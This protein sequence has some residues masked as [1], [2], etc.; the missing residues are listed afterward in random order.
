MPRSNQALLFLIGLVLLLHTSTQLSSYKALRSN[1]CPDTPRPVNK[2]IRACWDY[3]KNLE[4]TLV[5]KTDVKT[6][7]CL[8]NISPDYDNHDLGVQI[9]RTS[10]II[11]CFGI[12]QAGKFSWEDFTQNINGIWTSKS[13]IM[14]DPDICVLDGDFK[15]L[16]CM[17]MDLSDFNLL[18]LTVAE[19]ARLL[20]GLFIGTHDL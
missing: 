7:V 3:T 11:Y 20:E 17:D 12:F 4:T 9:M 2:S 19:Q 16:K 18:Y 15:D 1:K 13:E 5:E 8:N 10:K 6:D 14:E